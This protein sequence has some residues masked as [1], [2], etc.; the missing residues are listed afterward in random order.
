M[1][2][3]YPDSLTAPYVRINFI[4]SLNGKVAIE[5]RTAGFESKAD[6]IVFGRLRRLAD[7]IL[8]GAGTVRADSYRGA[9]SWEA[10]RAKRLERGQTEAAPIAIVTTSADLDVEGP[11]FTDTWV[12]PTVFT[13]RSAAEQNISRLAQAGAEIHIVGEE[14]AEVD[15]ILDIFARRGWYRVLCEGGPTLFDA[16]IKAEAVDEL[17]LTLSARIGGTGQISSGPA[18][19]ITSMHLGSVI[20]EDDDLFILYRREQ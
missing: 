11:L 3:R 12:P 14:S 7:V 6:Q 1:I 18:T 20:S 5:G 8:V 2:Y 19:G 4:T 17:C 10:L 9:R 13:V 15:Q 16:L